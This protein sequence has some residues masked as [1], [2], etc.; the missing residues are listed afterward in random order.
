MGYFARIFR[1][2]TVVTT[3]LI[4]PTSPARSQEPW[5]V[6]FPEQRCMQIRD[7]SQMP[8]ARL[9]RTPVPQTVSEPEFKFEPWRLSL[10]DAIR[11]AL[12]NAEVIRVLGGS[13]GRTIYD[14][15]VTNTQI[16]QARGGFDPTINLR[17]NFTRRDT[18]S[19]G[20]IIHPNTT[21]GVH[22]DDY[23][24]SL[25]L[26]KRT[27]TGGTAAL[28][29]GTQ[30]FDSLVPGFPLD[31]QIDSSA[32]MSLTQPLLRGAGARVNLAPIVIARIDTE[33][34]FFQMK[35][36]VQEL[37]RGV[38]DGYWSL[39]AARTDVWVRHQQVEQGAWSE[40]RAGARFEAGAE[41]FGDV[42]QSRAAL[43]GF[44]N[45]L[46]ASEANQ[47]QSEATLRNIL[48]L[49]PVDSRE[50][51]PITI[52]STEW[53]R[54][55]WEDIVAVA[56]ERRPD[57]IELKLILEADRQR[58]LVARNAA[59]PSVDA[60]ALYRWNGLEGRTPGGMYVSSGPGQFTGWQLGVNFSVP[61]GLRE[62]R[63]GLRRQELLIARDTAELDQALHNA[64]HRLV[65]TYRNLA[66]AYEQY[67]ISKDEKEAAL[68]NFDYQNEIWD[69]GGTDV[70]P[71]VYL[72]VWQ[73]ITQL[74]NARSA[75][76]RTLTQ[77]NTEM[78][79]L[80]RE[81]GAILEAHGI[82]FSEEWFA[83]IGPAGRLFEY[84]C[85]PRDMAPC[86][87][88]RIYQDGS[89]PSEYFFD[90]DE[91]QLPE[92]TRPLD[93]EGASTSPPLVPLPPV[94]EVRMRVGS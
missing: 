94:T 84:P 76:A 15:A 12:E 24:M 4:V 79:N 9:P 21:L 51:V 80:Q 2:C 91:Q 52:P 56:E 26:S 55:S 93:R 62:S 83:S 77:Y 92:H 50:I 59:L 66:Q 57:L 16:D 31:P 6:I 34:S 32:N 64:V 70:R 81:A 42:A 23:S 85:Y 18:P 82:R 49:P 8:V 69:A 88:D 86:P 38:I 5:H 14:P 30:R 20:A 3:L 54:D 13:S 17:N 40:K 73:A 39:V 33:R 43:A 78:A 90:L 48:G 41:D 36:G 37:V 63:A 46:K 25:G 74:A 44:H 58:L 19:S 60:V 45:A 35:D 65:A 22:A 75:E 7:P 89:E 71:V 87:N 68:I 29:M 61:L 27:I 47:L 72:N 28:Q 1:V 11:I 10:D 53:P 67:R